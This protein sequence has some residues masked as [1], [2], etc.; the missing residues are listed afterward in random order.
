MAQLPEI[1]G[2]PRGARFFR[3]DLHIH[4]V[5]GSHDVKDSSAAPERI[6][7]TAVKEG[8][9]II[10]IADH[11]EITGVASA[12]TAASAADI[13]VVPA[14]ELST[15]EGHLLCYLPSHDSLQRFHAQLAIADRNTANSRCQNA[16]LDCLDKLHAQSGFAILA[17]V[18]APG[19]LEIEVPSSSPHKADLLC[20]RALLG[21]ELRSAGSTISYSDHEPE[22]ERA[23]IGRERSRRLALGTYLSLARVLNSDAHTLQAL[24][25]N[26]SGDRRVTRYKMNALTFDSLRIALDDAGARVRIEDEVPLAVPFIKGIRMSGGFMDGQCIHFSPNLNCIIGGRG[27]GKSVTFEA[28][29]CLAGQPST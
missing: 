2:L 24:R 25:R 6:V 14:V 7:A 9:K 27:T 1:T 11:N 21:I 19:G 20:N 23:R 12:L 22:A 15:P 17:H 26:A 29:R 18:D 16:M 4:S 5:G 28:I 10:A 3:A 13:F 8:L